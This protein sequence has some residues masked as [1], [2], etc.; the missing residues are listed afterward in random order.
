MMKFQQIVM[1][2]DRNER[3][4]HAGDPDPE[5]PTGVSQG[6][7]AVCPGQVIGYDS[8]GRVYRMPERRR[9]TDPDAWGPW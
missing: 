9:Y 4:R 7:P 1:D 8:Q 2:L 6:N 3:G 5:D